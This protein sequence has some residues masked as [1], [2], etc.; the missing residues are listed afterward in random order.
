VDHEA[1]GVRIVDSDEIDI[2]LH[3]PRDEGYAARK[4]VELR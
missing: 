3:Q 4:P 2:A 1:I